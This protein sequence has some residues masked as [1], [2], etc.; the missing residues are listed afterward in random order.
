MTTPIFLGT[1]LFN[2]AG[3]FLEVFPSSSWVGATAKVPPQMDVH[4]QFGSCIIRGDATT[5]VTAQ[6]CIHEDFLLWINQ[7][8]LVKPIQMTAFCQTSLIATCCTHWQRNTKFLP[9]LT[10][11]SGH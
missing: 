3:T 2:E 8:W 5:C 1:N 7:E 4:G 10:L 6:T 11:A 9:A